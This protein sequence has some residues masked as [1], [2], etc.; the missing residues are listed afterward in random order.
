M[1]SNDP[2]QGVAK[3]C[4]CRSVGAIH[5]G[6]P[7]ILDF[8]AAFKE[9]ITLVLHIGHRMRSLKRLS[10]GEGRVVAARRNKAPLHKRKDPLLTTFWWRFWMAP[11]ARNK[12]GAHMFESEAFRKQMCCWRKYLWDYCDFSTPPG[13]LC[14]LVTPLLNYTGHVHKLDVKLKF[15]WEWLFS[16]CCA[17]ACQTLLLW[18]E[19]T[20]N[21]LRK[22]RW[23]TFLY[24]VL[25]AIIG[26]I[27][28]YCVIL[29]MV[30]L[31]DAMKTIQNY[32]F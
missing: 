29:K 1:S 17:H 3:G 27:S 19:L 28:H 14:P 11:V 7:L 10:K 23:S 16:V 13:E 30:I 12:F 5:Q 4:Y 24:S 32:F 21:T 18:S 2:R 31:H 25:N 15:V 8:K 22:Q 6:N 26:M 9:W 20:N